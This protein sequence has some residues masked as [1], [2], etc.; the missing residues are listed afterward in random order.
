MGIMFHTHDKDL[1][2]SSSDRTQGRSSPTRRPLPPPPTEAPVTD[3]PETEEPLTEEPE[4]VTYSSP[5]DPATRSRSGGEELTTRTGSAFDMQSSVTPTTTTTTTTTTTQ[6]T[7]TTQEPTT[8]TT[9]KNKW[10][11]FAPSKDI[12]IE[13][14][15]S[16]SECQ[17]T[18]F[19]C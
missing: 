14:S 19:W 12:S 1:H 7:T 9:E 4:P 11:T 15:A 2:T 16:S 8:T 13:A 17:Y 10:V 5:L 18:N 6:A 3:E